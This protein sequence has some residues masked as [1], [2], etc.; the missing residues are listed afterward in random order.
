M[1]SDQGHWYRVADEW[2]ARARTPNHHGFWA[3]RYTLVAFIGF[4]GRDRGE[5]LDVGRGEGRVSRVLRDCGYSV[6]RRIALAYA[7]LRGD[8][9]STRSRTIRTPDTDEIRVVDRCGNSAVKLGAGHWSPEQIEGKRVSNQ[10][11]A[12]VQ[13]KRTPFPPRRRPSAQGTADEVAEFVYKESS[14]SLED[15][16]GDVGDSWKVH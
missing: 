15:Q 5:A 8:R 11:P 3:H 13:A 10:R 2:L 1:R 6:R 7:G 9:D 14:V 16:L 4:I 12:V